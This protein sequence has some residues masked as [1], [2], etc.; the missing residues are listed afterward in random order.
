VA[1]VSMCCSLLL[2]LKP[3]MSTTPFLARQAW[4]GCAVPPD[5][6]SGSM[7]VLVPGV[8]HGSDNSAACP[9]IV[10]MV[11][12][13]AATASYRAMIIYPASIRYGREPGLV[14]LILLIGMAYCVAA[15][16]ITVF[17]FAYMVTA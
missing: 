11:F 2:T 12:R 14:L 10:H 6:L 15:P 4:L 7:P 9:A 8:A 16:L 3:A 13:H 17:V 1:N 5:M